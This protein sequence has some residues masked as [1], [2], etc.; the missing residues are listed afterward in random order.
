[1]PLQNAH[2][3]QRHALIAALVGNTL[4]WFDFVCY[5]ILAEY[6]SRSFFPSGNAEAAL[7]ATFALFGVGFVLRPLGGLVL[8]RM[9]DVRGRKPTFMLTIAL[10]SIGTLAIAFIPSYATIGIAA[11]LLLLLAR[12][13]QGFSAGGEWGVAIAFLAEWSSPG[14]RGYVSSFI[15]MTVAVGSLFA[16]G[17][18]AILITTLPPAEMAS[19]GWRVPFLIGGMLGLSGWWLRSFIDETPIYRSR[20]DGNPKAKAPRSSFLRG[21]LSCGLTVHWTVCFYMFLVYLPTYTRVQAHLSSSK[22]IW[23]NTL[24]LVTIVLLVP[25]VGRWSDRHGRKPFLLASCIIVALF[26]IPGLWLILKTQSFAVI[27]GVQI[28]FGIAIALY[29]GPSPAFMAELFPKH[30]RARLSG[31]SYAIVTALFGGFAPFI[32]D[33]LVHTWDSPYAP[34]LYAIAAAGI[35]GLVVASTSETVHV[36]LE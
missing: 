23:S 18:A 34:A 7:L 29:S 17:M 20:V 31:A 19:W 6:I 33:W 11:P 10:M 24:C 13:L 30:N 12:L 35:S 4:E 32:A 28:I 21:L 14:R 8:G 26:S 2:R 27:V 15:S 3:R 36:P 9:G 22:S 16:S 25:V 5:R 1:M